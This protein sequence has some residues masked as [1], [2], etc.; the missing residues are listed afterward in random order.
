MDKTYTIFAGVNGAGKSTLYQLHSLDKNQPRVNTDEI[1]QKIGDWKNVRD[2]IKAGK[3]AVKNIKDYITQG[4]SF[5]QETT[6]TGK[7]IINNIAKAKENGYQVILHYIG[8]ESAE[9]AKKRVKQRVFKGGHDIPEDIIERR[10]QESFDNLKIAIPYCDKVNIY[11]NTNMLTLICRI[12]DSSIRWANRCN[13]FEP[14]LNT[15]ETEQIKKVIL[16]SGYSPTETLIYDMMNI[17]KLF[18]NFYT[19]KDIKEIYK[20]IDFLDPLRRE[21]VNQAANHFIQAERKNQKINNHLPE[22]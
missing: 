14:I 15:Y 4:I 3:I 5:N 10:Y 8:L 16:Q 22:R 11:D 12:E 18:N 6:L 9:L 17:N 7:S 20:N 2:Q 21:A 13:W 1:V 19:V